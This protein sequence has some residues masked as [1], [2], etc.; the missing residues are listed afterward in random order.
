MHLSDTQ[1]VCWHDQSKRM[2]HLQLP[3][4][5]EM[6]MPVKSKAL[7]RTEVHGL[8]AMKFKLQ[9]QNEH[10]YQCKPPPRHSLIFFYYHHWNKREQCLSILNYLK[11]LHNILSWLHTSTMFL[12]KLTSTYFS[13]FETLEA[14]SELYSI[15]F[16]Y[17]ISDVYEHEN[18][19][20]DRSAR[21]PYVASVVA[22]LCCLKIVILLS[23]A[24]L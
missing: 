21:T 14:K 18:K 9:P 20:K 10:K 3:W 22:S 7:N 23:Q 24:R 16:E 5:W 1:S 17:F 19:G 12:S 15:Y 11:V 13:E 8:I 2:F 6:S 4:L